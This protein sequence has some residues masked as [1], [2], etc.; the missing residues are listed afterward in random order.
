M[1]IMNTAV[2]AAIAA[3]QPLKNLSSILEIVY[4]IVLFRD[5]VPTTIALV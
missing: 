3:K 1:T 2:R 5:N 4:F